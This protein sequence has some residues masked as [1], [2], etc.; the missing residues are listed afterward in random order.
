MKRIAILIPIFCLLSSFSW[1]TA[2]V[3]PQKDVNDPV[4]RKVD[5]N[6][7]LNGEFLKYKIHYGLINAGFAEMKIDEEPVMINDRA[8]Y[9][10]TGKGYSNSFFDAFYRV[11]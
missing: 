9:H 10:I 11:R 2:D 3:L 4:L 7:F 1:Y 8:C 6:T 5:N